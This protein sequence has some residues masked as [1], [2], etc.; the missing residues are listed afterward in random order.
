MLCIFPSRLEQDYYKT[1]TLN[2]FIPCLSFGDT[3][4]CISR[5]Y[6]KIIQIFW[7]YIK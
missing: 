4:Y 6:G 3:N 2:E 1:V 5:L 7:N